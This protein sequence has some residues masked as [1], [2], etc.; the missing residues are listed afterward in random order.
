MLQ[1]WFNSLLLIFIFVSVACRELVPAKKSSGQRLR[2]LSGCQWNGPCWCSSCTSGYTTSTHCKNTQCDAGKYCPG[3]GY[4]YDCDDITS[5]SGAFTFSGVSICNVSAKVSM[6]GRQP[7][8]VTR[9]NYSLH[10]YITCK[11]KRVI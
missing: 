2:L 8:S 6:H 4:S 7:H 9:E 11:N 5:C 1:A 10:F 3:D